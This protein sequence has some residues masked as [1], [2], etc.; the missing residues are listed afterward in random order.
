MKEVLFNK[1][2]PRNKVCVVSGAVLQANGLRESKLFDDI[3]IIMTSDLR[4]LYGRELGVV[5]EYAEMHPQNEYIICDDE[6][7]V[8]NE[9]HFFRT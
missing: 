8:N 9:N 3:D 5:S 1:N 2:I 7:I 4:E 6:I